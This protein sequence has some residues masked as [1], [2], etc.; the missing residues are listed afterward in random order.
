MRCAFSFPLT[1]YI[2]KIKLGLSSRI[3]QFHLAD[4]RGDPPA[5]PPSQWPL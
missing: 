1:L 4:I 5:S 3:I 2:V